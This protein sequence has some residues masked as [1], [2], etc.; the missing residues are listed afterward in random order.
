MGGC[1]LFSH[2]VNLD[3]APSG[4]SVACSGSFAQ[5]HQAVPRGSGSVGVPVLI[6]MFLTNVP[7]FSNTCTR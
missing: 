5:H 6:Q 3:L 1:Q 7:F 4:P 2:R